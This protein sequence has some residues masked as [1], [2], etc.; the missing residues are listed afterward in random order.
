[1][2]PNKRWLHASGAFPQDPSENDINGPIGHGTGVLAKA[3]GW[4]HGI[5]K[6]ANPVIVRV[7]KK[8]DPAAWLDGVRQAYKDWLP[9]YNADVSGCYLI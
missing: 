4:K 8:G 9:I 1:M 5:A 2:T 3:V 6:R 7:N